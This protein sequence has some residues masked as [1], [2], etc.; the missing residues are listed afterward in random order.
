MEKNDTIANRVKIKDKEMI[1]VNNLKIDDIIQFENEYSNYNDRLKVVEIFDS[2]I[3]F[4][5]VKKFT[6]KAILKK[7]LMRAK[8][9]LITWYEPFW[10]FCKIVNNLFICAIFF[11]INI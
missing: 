5:N 11:K 10:S 7:S 6:R 1:H 2:Y 4:I 9:H 3:I 8:W